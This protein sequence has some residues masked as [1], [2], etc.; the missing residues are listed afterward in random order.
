MDYTFKQESQAAEPRGLIRVIRIIRVRKTSSSL[1]FKQQS[2]VGSNPLKSV[3]S[4]CEIMKDQ[5]KALQAIFLACIT[6]HILITIVPSM[7]AVTYIAS[8][9][10]SLPGWS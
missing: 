2:P 4:V 8:D 6:A 5:G 7:Y 9:V 1:W 10:Y 3:V